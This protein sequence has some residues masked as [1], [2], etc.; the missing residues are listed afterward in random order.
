MMVTRQQGGSSGAK[1]L[2]LL[3]NLVELMGYWWFIQKSVLRWAVVCQL[4]CVTTIC[5][6]IS[7]GWRRLTEDS[8][9]FIFRVTLMDRR[10]L[11]KRLFS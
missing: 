7:A 4:T 8:L 11:F 3:R 5:N 6:S 1:L 9:A 10:K 2:Q